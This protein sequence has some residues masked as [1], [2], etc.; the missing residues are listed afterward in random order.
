VLSAPDA[1]IGAENEENRAIADPQD[2][3][4]SISRLAVMQD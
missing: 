4:L 3:A 1:G 2:A